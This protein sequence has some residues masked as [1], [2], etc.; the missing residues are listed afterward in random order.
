MKLISIGAIS[1]WGA[2]IKEHCEAQKKSQSPRTGEIPYPFEGK[3]R[4]V[5]IESAVEL[6]LTLPVPDAVLR[7]SSR[8]SQMSLSA[9]E[10]AKKNLG[11]LFEEHIHTKKIGILVGAPNGPAGIGLDYTKKL[12]R[13]QYK[14]A[15]PNL[16]AQS[17]HNNLASTIAL[18]YGLKGPTLTLLQRENLWSGLLEV[19]DLWLKE[20]SADY[21]WLVVGNELSEHFSYSQLYAAVKNNLVTD[22]SPLFIPDESERATEGFS[23]FLLGPNNLHIPAFEERSVPFTIEETQPLVDKIPVNQ[24]AP[25][26]QAEK[27]GLV[28]AQHYFDSS[29]SD[30]IQQSC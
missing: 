5:Q 7:R 25:L 11:G 30:K 13:S 22:D 4:S 29:F 19:A 27:I 14:G 17:V 1:P 6:K 2:T 12:V 18:T 28:V 21:V 26:G 9:I 20:K 15:S 24:K 10:D 23:A 8:S 3:K 16:F